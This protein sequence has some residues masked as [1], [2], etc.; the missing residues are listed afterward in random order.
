MSVRSALDGNGY[1]TEMSLDVDMG[2]HDDE[3]DD[4]GV[5]HGHSHSSMMSLEAFANSHSHGSR[6]LHKKRTPKQSRTFSKSARASHLVKAHALHRS[7][8]DISKIGFD[9]RHDFI[10][11][12]KRFVNPRDRRWMPNRRM[13]AQAA[14]QLLDSAHMENGNV[15]RCDVSSGTLVCKSVD[16]QGCAL[17]EYSLD[18]TPT[19]SHVETL[20]DTVAI[21][22]T[23]FVFG[24]G[25][26]STMPSGS[27]AIIG[28][29]CPW[30][31][32]K[33]VRFWLALSV[34]AQNL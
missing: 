18:Y 29:Y 7:L 13:D 22:D 8:I 3:D 10:R 5:A 4:H 30:R 16:C 27:R 28:M 17:Y 21:G 32:L 14:V 33:R 6:K 19:L 34:F 20:A 23:V 11:P 12:N 15:T 31:H 1:S 25:F 24:F 26:Q 2:M 9:D